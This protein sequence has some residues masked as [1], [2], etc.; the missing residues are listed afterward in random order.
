[1]LKQLLNEASMSNDQSV[2]L[3]IFTEDANIVS[4]EV[5]WKDVTTEGSAP[6]DGVL[7]IYSSHGLGMCLEKSIDI[8]SASNINDTSIIDIAGPARTVF[9]EYHHN[10]INGGKL[11]AVAVLRRI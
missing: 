3:P 6:I 9:L 8:T 5:M 2:E 11:S 1:M 7:N 10:A 4:I